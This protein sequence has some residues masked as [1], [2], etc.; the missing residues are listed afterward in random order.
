VSGPATYGDLA[1]SLDG[2]KAAVSLVDAQRNEDVWVLDL[3]RG[4]LPTRFTFD[5]GRDFA[6]VWSQDGSRVAFASDR[7]GSGPQSPFDLYQKPTSGIGSEEVLAADNLSKIPTSWSPDGRFMLYTLQ[8]NRG[9][10]DLWVLPLFG[11]RKP[12]PFLQTRFNEGRGQFSP[13]GRGI[14]Y[15]SNES[16]PDEVYV[17]PF[18]GQGGGP[19]G[20]WQVSTNGG[21]Q[22]Q[23]RGDGNEIFFVSPAPDNTLMV[24]AVTA[25]DS[26]FD[27]GAIKPLFAIRPS[28][29]PRNSY[30][31]SADGRRFLVN[32]SEVQSATRMPTPI[33]VVVNW[34]AGFKK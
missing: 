17:A 30:Q 24:A 23:W 34:T 29:T 15:V 31:V 10:D 8:T 7:K 11:D 21:S 4:A 2:K 26:G 1:L 32:M 27:V 22:P 28:G 25:R 19:G 9:F 18:Q 3:D 33:T 6:P 14:V 13:D 5:T 16:G 12:F 20:K